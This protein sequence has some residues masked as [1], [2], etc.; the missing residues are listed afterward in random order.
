M[1]KSLYGFE[2]LKERRFF[3]SESIKNRITIEACIL[4]VISPYKSL[5]MIGPYRYATIKKL[6]EGDIDIN[7]G[8]H[9]VIVTENEEYGVV[10]SPYSEDQL[11]SIYGSDDNI[12]GRLILFDTVE[13]SS[14]SFSAV[15]NV[16]FKGSQAEE[17]EDLDRMLPLTV[18]GIFSKHV[19]GNV[20]TRRFKG[21]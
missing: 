6:L 2:R 11:R 16:R 12:K 17:P 14:M 5:S 9:F 13:R 18:A 19:S 1:V 10:E 4:E 8:I 3:E 7:S 20:K 21:V 15:K